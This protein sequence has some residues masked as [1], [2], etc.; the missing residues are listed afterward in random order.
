MFENNFIDI[1]THLL[2]IQDGPADIEEA[3]RT[4]RIAKENGI[5]EIV[6]T[7]HYMPG[8]RSYSSSD[9]YSLFKELD[10]E[11]QKRGLRVKLYLGNECVIAKG[12]VEDIKEGRAFTLG[13]TRY[14]LCEYPFYQ[15]PFDFMNILYELMDIGYKP[16]IA[17]PERNFYIRSDIE[18]LLELKNNGCLIQLNAESLLGAYGNTIKKFSEKL[19]KDQ[20]VDFIASD[21]HNCMRRSPATL[22][23]AY[24][25][26]EKLIRK[27][28]LAELINRPKAILK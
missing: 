26:A 14:V 16:I 15:V 28:Y 25:K 3:V 27:D 8:D 9:V 22:K 23:K 10:E 18:N 1:H 13:G 12:I 6:L 19:L 4:V 2:P 5:S 7:P 11:T 20:V 21:A 24:I 17:H